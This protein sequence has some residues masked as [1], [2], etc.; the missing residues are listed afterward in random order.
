[1]GGANLVERAA[2]GDRGRRFDGQ[3]SARLR[4]FA[5][6]K[7]LCQLFRKM[8]GRLPSATLDIDNVRRK[9]AELVP[10]DHVGRGAAGNFPG[11]KTGQN[12]AGDESEADAMA[13]SDEPAF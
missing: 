6:G 12:S 8:L 3:F 5:A 2:R 7:F 10:G 1:M 9:T 11:V 13:V 4:L